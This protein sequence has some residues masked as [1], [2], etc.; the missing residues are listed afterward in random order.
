M[1]GR[2]ATLC[3][4]LLIACLIIAGLSVP[5]DRISMVQADIQS[6]SLA[7]MAVRIGLF[8][9]F[10]TLGWHRF[11]RFCVSRT[12]RVLADSRRRVIGWYALTEAVILAT[13]VGR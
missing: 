7:L 6:I 3:C 12:G 1:I 9:V 5:V 2:L 11:N 13:I 10:I 8:V 4:L